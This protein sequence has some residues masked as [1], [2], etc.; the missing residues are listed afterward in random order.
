MFLGEPTFHFLGERTFRVFRKQ[1]DTN[2]LL[3][4]YITAQLVYYATVPVRHA[5]R[6]FDFLYLTEGNEKQKDVVHSFYKSRYKLDSG[7]DSGRYRG[8]KF[9]I[10]A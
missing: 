1:G 4:G 6:T 2:S 10:V 7:W 8:W 9:F 5:G 3:E